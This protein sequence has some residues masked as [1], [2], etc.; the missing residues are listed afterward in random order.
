M[1]NVKFS[2]GMRNNML[3]GTVAIETAFDAG[4]LELRDGAQPASANAAPTGVLISSVTVPASAF[5]AIANG[6]LSED[7][8]AWV[9]L[10]AVAAG[11]PTW[12]R[13]KSS[14]DGGLLSTTDIRVDGDVTTTA[15][16][17]GDLQMVNTTIAA[18]DKITISTFT[19]TIP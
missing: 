10:S 18:A 14:T 19:I 3:S 16:G 9:D 13:L 4:V 5:G 6:V 2:E 11:T 7:T 8:T 1:A 17:T 12:F 15:V